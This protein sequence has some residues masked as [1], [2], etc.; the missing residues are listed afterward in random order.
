[1]KSLKNSRNLRGAALM[2]SLVAMLAAMMLAMGLFALSGTSK[3]MTYRS[4]QKTQADMLAE[5]G[6][7]ALYA[8][9]VNVPPNSDVINMAE[10]LPTDLT[11]SYG[12]V[13]MNEGKYSAKVLSSS[14]AVV[15]SL[16]IYTFKVEG[17]GIAE[18]NI[19][20]VRRTTFTMTT[21]GPTTLVLGEGAIRS[22]GAV[23]IGG[24]SYTRDPSGNAAAG[25]YSNGVLT[26]LGGSTPG[27]L[28][29]QGT[30]GF[31]TASPSVVPPKATTITP[32]AAPMSFPTN[33]DVTEWRNAW[34]ASA[35]QP[36]PTYPAGKILGPQIL[37][38]NTTFVGPAEINGNL[39]I[40]ANKVLTLAADPAASKPI[41]VFVRGNVSCSG[42]GSIVNQGVILVADGT[43]SISG[44]GQTYSVANN[45]DCGMISYSANPTSAITLSGGT[46]TQNV[47]VLYAVNGGV[48]VSGSSTFV[49][50]IVARGNP[51]TTT[52][53][54][55][56]SIQYSPG[57]N[58]QFEPFMQG[59]TA[60]A[61]TRWARI[62]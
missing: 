59:Y 28:F 44:N 24:G 17:R 62:K 52:V 33:A 14:S 54:G 51:S 8:Q 46:L 48:T 60:S 37:T 1:M 35:R 11:G 19:E 58:A 56:A 47:G 41:V 16:T 22:A 61:L 27:N 2:L 15:S 50:S 21:K 5:A 42:G 3:R 45:Q 9:M 6:L 38:A 57:A 25:V 18:N 29:V 40:A 26:F 20:S 31:A 7:H 55:G 12:G 10:I 49:G 30:A 34:L 32:M 43:I 13:S 23:T 36:T 53:T 39:S 4:W